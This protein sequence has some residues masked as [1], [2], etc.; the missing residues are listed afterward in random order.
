MGYFKYKCG[1]V[2]GNFIKWT[3]EICQ[4]KALKYNTR[5]EFKVKSPR[6]YHASRRN[7]WM[8]EICGHMDFAYKWDRQNYE[9]R[10][11]V[12]NK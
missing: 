3:K 2:G 9:D 11:K 1:G 8:D 10:I 7:K 5:N 12:K 4:K 6:A